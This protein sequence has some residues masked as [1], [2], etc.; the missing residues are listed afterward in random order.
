[1]TDHSNT[2]AP[3]EP[4]THTAGPLRLA[5]PAVRRLVVTRVK[6]S[7]AIRSRD[8]KLADYAVGR[9]L[10]D[11]GNKDGSRC[12]P[13]TARLAND[14][15]CTEKT[16]KRSLEALTEGGW[17]ILANPGVRYRGVANEYQLTIPAPV[18]AVLKMWPEE[19]E[20][21]TG[22][23]GDAGVTLTL[24]GYEGVVIF[25]GG[26]GGHFFA[27]GGRPCPDKGV[28]G[29]PPPGDHPGFSHHAASLTRAHASAS[30]KRKIA[31]IVEDLDPDD[32]VGEVLHERIEDMLGHELGLA[33]TQRLDGMLGSGRDLHEI[34]AVALADPH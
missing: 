28:P 25:F 22:N 21:W 4:A 27:E 26:E 30:R 2:F 3:R 20:H 23:K 12:R 19:V 13:G 8:L 24:P 15:S 10:A 34:V 14:L 33:A 17:L 31:S 6:W 9:A 32:D 5:R 7:R 16:V 11:Y 1:M 29:V 18:A